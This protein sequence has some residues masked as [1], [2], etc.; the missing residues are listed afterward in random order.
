MSCTNDIDQFQH[1]ETGAH[2]YG[3]TDLTYLLH[4]AHVP[5]AYYVEAGDAPDC[6][7]DATTCPRRPQSAAT[8]SIWNPLPDFTTVADDREGGRV[9][10]VGAFLAAARHGG[11]PAVSWV[12]PGFDDSEHPNALLSAGQDYVRTLVNAVTSG[13]EW[14]S[15][16][17]FLTWDDW[18]GFYDHV[19]PPRV[20]ENG[21]GLRVP[22][23]VISP[24]ARPHFIDHQVV[25]FDAYAKFIEDDFL[26]GARLDPHL[27]GRPDRRPSVR[28]AVGAL[29]DLSRDFDFTQAPLPPVTVPPL[30]R[31]P[32]GRVSAQLRA[33]AGAH[34]ALVDRAVADRPPGG[35]VA[36]TTTVL[37]HGSPRPARRAQTRRPWAAAG[38]AA[39]VA[40]GVL[41]V[42]A[43]RRRY[44]MR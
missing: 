32:S 30:L 1:Y 34:H 15:T 17:I 26:G 16:A 38:V 19:A 11:L 21:Y 29:G 10:D 40:A 39:V 31:A 14:G 44:A 3:W 22:G 25:S 27:D 28:E 42:A 5:W 12:V 43:S 2:D 20:D 41:A 4:R 24:F 23:L 7:D 13:P 37:L 35:A 6:D 18:G 36:T 9:Q 33:S 8:P